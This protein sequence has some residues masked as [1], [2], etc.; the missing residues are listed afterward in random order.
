MNVY[1][2]AQGYVRRSA[3]KLSTLVYSLN[4]GQKKR[5]LVFLDSLSFLVS[6]YLAFCFRFGIQVPLANIWRYHW[7]IIALILIKV[8]VFQALGIYRPVLRYT[9]G[10]FLATA[11]KAVLLSLSTLVVLAYLLESFQLPRTVLINDALL[12]LLF[13]VSIRLSMR[14]LTRNLQTLAIATPNQKPERVV[15]YGAGASG[16]EL[17]QALANNFTYRLIGFVDDNPALHRHVVQGLTV[18]PPSDLFQIQC[19]RGL[20]TILLA[21]PSINGQ[22]R[23]QIITYLQTLN[24]QVKTVPSVS[25][26]LSGD[27]SVSKIRQ[28]DIA[29]LLGREQVAPNLEL[30][31][32]D[33]T[34]KSVLVTGAGG[35]IGSELCR[36]IAAQHP[37]C[38][39]LFELN[40]FALYNID[41]ELTE[42]FPTLNKVACLGTVTDATYLQY[43]MKQH[44]VATVYHAAAY[45]HVPLVEANPSQGILNNIQGTLT[46]VR[47]AINC[48]V[49]KFVLISTDKAVR[50]TNVMGASKR[51]AELILQAL[52]DL[53]PS[54]CLTMVR[55]GNVLGSS[56][57]VVP[58]FRQQIA[59]GKSI[60]LTHPNIT[61][62][63]MSIPEAASLVIQA[64]AMSQGGEVFLLNMGEPVRIQDLAIQ[65]IRL[66]GLEPG[67]DVD[68]RITGLRPG[69]KIY[70]ELLIDCDNAKP[71][72]HP[73]IFCA[74]E[75]KVSWEILEPQLAILFFHAR[76]NDYHACLRILQKIVP[77][78]QRSPQ[79]HLVH[80]KV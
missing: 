60:T 49:A 8:F 18:Y 15:I 14:Y 80:L 44:Q 3:R 13:I 50:P 27:I 33:I 17:A 32:T 77:E 75:L 29:D 52:A 1:Q 66:S 16:S 62:Y 26:I 35:S 63:F 78:Y 64:G 6:I 38:L 24:V 51:V 11:F 31:Q 5:V 61:R 22:R 72:R 54:T 45:K 4:R 19:K 79:S 7:L 67:R 46:A 59:E 69:E 42:S 40:E 21:M 74:H 39:I 20:D 68:I 47:C 70:E 12:T 34:G 56:G 2:K 37:D 9:G 65:M 41:I 57:S 76:Q 55:F 36:Q 10:E 48:G 30:L 25:E 43:L 28:I 23:K 58:R 53:Y 73:K 71:T